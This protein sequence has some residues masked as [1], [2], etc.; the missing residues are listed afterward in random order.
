MPEGQTDEAIFSAVIPSSK[1]TLMMSTWQ[2][3]NQNNCYQHFSY[4]KINTSLIFLEEWS[5]QKAPLFPRYLENKRRTFIEFNLQWS[6]LGCSL[7]ASVE[8][9]T[10]GQWFSSFINDMN[11]ERYTQVVIYW[12]WSLWKVHLIWKLHI[13]K[14]KWPW[15]FGDEMTYA[16]FP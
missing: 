16:F 11:I 12:L 14:K 10:H 1:I 7:T 9:L 15:P 5:I 13:T 3:A 4:R 8:F 2:K 6:F